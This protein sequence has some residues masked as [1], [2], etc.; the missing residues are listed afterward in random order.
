MLNHAQLLHV[1]SLMPINKQLTIFLLKY[2]TS[3]KTVTMSQSALHQGGRYMHGEGSMLIIIFVFSSTLAAQFTCGMSSKFSQTSI[4]E[5]RNALT[6]AL[7]LM[8]GY[9]AWTVDEVVQY[10]PTALYEHLLL[11]L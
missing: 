5:R 2:V 3:Q 1:F 4:D 9:R 10:G 8:Y 7:C 11:V 6:S